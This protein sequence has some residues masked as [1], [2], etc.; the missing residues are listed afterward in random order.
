MALFDLL[1]GRPEDVAPRLLGAT[2]RHVTDEGPVSLVLTETEAYGG[3]ADPASHAWRGRRPRN[4]SMYM[5]A[6]HAYI[7]QTRHHLALN[8]V[9]GPQDEASAV[10]LRAGRVTEGESLARASRG[11]QIAAQRL[12]RGPANLARSLSLTLDLDGLDLMGEGPLTLTLG[13][14]VARIDVGPRVGVTRAQDV[15]WRF[16]VPGDSTVSAYRRASLR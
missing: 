6:G 16:S 5:P 2:V 10:L 4:L 7:Y 3:E 12:A 8:V 9:T 14:Q 13:D 15:Q 1:A 11:P